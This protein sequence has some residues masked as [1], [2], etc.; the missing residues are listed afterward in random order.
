MAKK[1]LTKIL[2]LIPAGL[3]ILL[4]IVGIVFLANLNSI[5]KVAVEKVMSFV[6]QV[7]VTLK[8]AQVSILGGS[9]ELQGLIIG[10]PEG[11]KTQEAFSVDKVNVKVSLKSFRTDEPTVN[12]ISIKNPKITL[13]QGLRRSNLSQ[14]I[15]N[16]S[17]FETEEAVEEETPKEAQ[18]KVKIDR[19]IVDGAEVA[20]S[21]P[22]LQGQE[23]SFP[24]PKIELNNIGGEKKPVTIPEAIR[25]FF[26]KI[27]TQAI[28]AGKGIIP[29]DLEKSLKDSLKSALEGVTEVPEI[30]KQEMGE[31]LKE[32][33]ETIKEELKGVKEGI[34]GLLKKD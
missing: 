7:D 25:I 2:I 27:L 21:A 32:G 30:L 22:V 34:K 14:L 29:P 12:L 8:K 15:K 9:V 1:K 3:I 26:T 28:T 20:L 11:F 6:L 13:E 33:E 10:N 18:K 17:R 23:M 31:Q 19:V 24:L 5:V 16:A 4:L